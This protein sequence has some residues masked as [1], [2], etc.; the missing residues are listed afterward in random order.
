VVVLNE[1]GEV[2]AAGGVVCRTAADG[3]LEV[4]LVHR[5]QYDDWTIPKGK[6]EDGESDEDCAAREVEEEAGVRVRLLDELPSVRWI[7]RFDRPKV[8]RYWRMEAV[9]GSPP[10][11]PQHEVDEVVWLPVEEAAARLSYPRDVEVLGPL[12]PPGQTLPR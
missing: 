1:R 9:E 3:R 8:S 12:L 6:V 7:D 10:A 5:S 2:R 4:L 11:T